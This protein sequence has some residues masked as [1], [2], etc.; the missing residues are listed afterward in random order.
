MYW[1]GPQGNS[2]QAFSLWVGKLRRGEEKSLPEFSEPLDA[3]VR[4]RALRPPCFAESCE[5]HPGASHRCAAW[6]F[7]PAPGQRLGP[8]GPRG[9]SRLALRPLLPARF[10]PWVRGSGAVVR[11]S[12]Q[13]SC[14]SDLTTASG[15]AAQT[16]LY[17][18]YEH[19]EAEC[20]CRLP[21]VLSE[22][23]GAET[24]LREKPRLPQRG[25]RGP[26]GRAGAGSWSLMFAGRAGNGVGRKC[27]EVA[28]SAHTGLCL[29]W[30]ALCNPG[31][32]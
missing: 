26:F 31:C 4:S 10:Q 17:F 15:D 16:A 14:F 20:R 32:A 11:T 28:S 22:G 3:R 7:L 29:L 13:A 9:G 6:P 21:Q 18:T 24:N 8:P 25:C 12:L 5:L 23:A 19:E 1:Q 2:A 30:A 27:L